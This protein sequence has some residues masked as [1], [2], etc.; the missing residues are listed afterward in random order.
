MDNI[1]WHHGFNMKFGLYEWDPTKGRPLDQELRPG[2]EEL[3]RVHSTW[4][5]TCLEIREF[6]LSTEGQDTT[7]AGGKG[8]K[9]WQGKQVVGRDVEGTVPDQV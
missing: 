9:R 8:G 5:E 2:G 7:A 3:V 1:E 4:P 6:A